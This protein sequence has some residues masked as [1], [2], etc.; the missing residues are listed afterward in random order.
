MSDIRN[1]E[2]MHYGVLGMKWGV[3]RARR[4]SNSGNTEKANKIY[5]KTFAKSSKTIDKAHKKAVK[6]NLKSAKL[7]KKALKKEAKATSE[8]QYN[9]AR[10]TQFKANKRRLKSAKLEKKAMKFEK[11]MSKVFADVSVKDI[12][13]ETLE[14]GK[15]YVYM[16]MTK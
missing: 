15:K 2:L 13:K 7:Q 6:K 5:S 1:D 14:I 9:K 12:D 10:K 4:A 3:R 16:L 8:A 11:K